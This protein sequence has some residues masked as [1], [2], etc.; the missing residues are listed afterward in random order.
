[1]LSDAASILKLF[2]IVYY[3]FMSKFQIKPAEPP[4]EA[5]RI[6]FAEF[7]ESIPPYV[8]KRIDDLYVQETSLLGSYVWGVTTPDIQLHCGSQSCGG[9]RFFSGKKDVLSGPDPI[10]WTPR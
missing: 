4:S 10:R 7:L 1:M 3:F 5:A 8:T 2:W 9:L 6:Q